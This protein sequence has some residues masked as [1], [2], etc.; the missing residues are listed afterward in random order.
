MVGAGE[1]SNRLWVS[2][3]ELSGN[4]F[5]TATLCH[6]L[7]LQQCWGHLSTDQSYFPLEKKKIRHLFNFICKGAESR[8]ITL[9]SFVYERTI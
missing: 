1:E 7:S 4:R 2:A 9:L 5:C 6:S 3:K 8:K